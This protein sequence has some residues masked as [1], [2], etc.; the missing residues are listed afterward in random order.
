MSKTEPA[1]T[2][3]EGSA[4]ARVEQRAERIRT[5]ELERALGELAHERELTDDQRAAVE[6]LSERLVDRVLA[7]PR[8]RLR[9]DGVREDDA[10]AT[11]DAL[12]S[13]ENGR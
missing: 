9:R 5:E 8:T 3:D 2:T 4:L 13:P 6:A 10:A 7:G 12:F 1:S 11:V